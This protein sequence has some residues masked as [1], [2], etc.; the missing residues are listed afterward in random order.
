MPTDTLTPAELKNF[1]MN[2]QFIRER[3]W[4]ILK[5]LS[6][7]VSQEQHN[8]EIQDL[9]LRSL[10]N[11]ES[12]GTCTPI[13]DRI[14]RE[15][16]LFPYLFPEELETA[17]Q[18]AYEFHRPLNMDE[19]DIVFHRPQG[20]V[21]RELLA[22]KSVVLSAPTSFG[23]SLI[24]D[25]I[26]ASGNF[27]NILL[28]VPTLALIDETRRRLARFHVHY[29]IVTHPSQSPA[30]RNI[31]VLTQ[32]RVLELARLD[33]IDFFVIDEFYKLSPGREDDERWALLNQAFYRLIK[34]GKQFYMLGPGVSGISGQ[35][36][37]RFEF[38][39]L[40]EPYHTVVSEIHRVE[41]G[42]NDLITLQNLCRE[43]PD[44][45]IIFTSSPQRAAKVAKALAE[46]EIGQIDPSRQGAVEWIGRNYHEDWH[47][48]KALKVG[49]G[50]HH[51][52]I[53]RA[54]GQ[55]VV[56]A[57]NSEKIRFLVCTSTLI[58]GVNTK[59][60]NIVVFDNEINRSALDLFTFNNIRGR[61]GRMFKHFIG[62]VY[63]FHPLP[64]GEL[65]L[66]EIPAFTQPENTP[67]SLLIQL[68]TN[69][70]TS[71]SQ[72]RLLAYEQQQ[73]LSIATIK[74]NNGI[75]PGAQL[76]LAREILENPTD[77]WPYLNWS[78]VSPRYNQLGKV[79]D[80][81]WRH[82]EGRR[83]AR[84]SVFSSKQL[85]FLIS[86]LQQKP[87]LKE[88]INSQLQFESDPDQVVSKTLDFLRLWAEFH[89]PRILRAFDRIQKEIFGKALIGSRGLR[90]I[91]CQGGKSI[92]RQRNC[93]SR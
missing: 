51:G 5:N 59:A 64:Q 8:P 3:S 62:H 30:E 85:T 58:E 29:K 86:R 12:F 52:R 65:P 11:R 49:V 37:S 74:A 44:Q 54:L 23:K 83:L 14:A 66:V 93:H 35:F 90:G 1:L 10:E 20:R 48:V 60:K 87:T 41:P 56:R 26:V 2:P 78:G 24:I 18:I 38:L 15:I 16:G 22:G 36:Q 75:D 89:F 84:G 17:D 76:E 80:L 92:F 45:T 32:E 55:Y 42:E 40:H 21:Y 82:F 73:D 53:P 47:F 79:C 91:F 19:E 33:K 39:F 77:L 67:D 6:G 28:V 69:D 81:I 43:L 71:E 25:A 9:V 68:D 4:Q 61:A 88:L 57:F 34:T 27:K 46:L 70:L 31:F 13:L 50:V 7:M 72:S 63:L